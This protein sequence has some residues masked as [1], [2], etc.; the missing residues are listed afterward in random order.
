MVSTGI[1]QLRSE[2]DILYLRKSFML[3]KTDDEA[4]DAFKGL[5]FESLNTKRTQ[6]RIS[7]V[8]ILK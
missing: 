7:A 1:P 2:K 5:I 6:V 3:E 8:F 4:A